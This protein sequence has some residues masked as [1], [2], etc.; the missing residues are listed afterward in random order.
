M[1]RRNSGAKDRTRRR[2]TGI[3]GG[4]SISFGG[5]PAPLPPASEFEVFL[6][7]LDTNEVGALRTFRRRAQKLAENPFVSD[8]DANQHLM[9]DRHPATGALRVSET[10]RLECN[11]QPSTMSPWSRS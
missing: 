9:F 4:H 8:G 3:P 5:A 6:S 7:S 2:I 11:G 1:S 10:L